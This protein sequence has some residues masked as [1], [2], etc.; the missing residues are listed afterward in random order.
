[1]TEGFFS[2]DAFFAAAADAYYPGRSWRPA[3]VRA[4]EHAWR[5]LEVGDGELVHDC[6]FLDYLEPLPQSGG[7]VLPSRRARFLRRTLARVVTAEQA[8]AVEPSSLV[9]PFIRWTSFDS[10]EAFRALVRSRSKSCFTKADRM[11][12]K[13][14]REVGELRFVEHSDEASV[15]EALFRFK[16]AQYLR[17]GLP[18]LFA[19]R[20]TRRLFENLLSAGALQMSVLY[21]GERI[22]ALHAGPRHGDRFLHWVPTYDPDL[23]RYAPGNTLNHELMRWSFDAGDAVFDLLLGDEPYKWRYATHVALVEP[24]GTPPLKERLRVRAGRLA[25]RA[26]AASPRA[27]GLA[28]ELRRRL[29]EREL[30]P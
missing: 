17:T 12:R 20:G 3:V 2:S 1:M 27:Y 8:S 10:F 21:A 28:K 13:L 26:F 19:S 23:G 15:L 4:G 5:V 24:I 18:D 6:R 14:G 30:L 9:A 25:R 16:S 22:A 29:R 11:A 7:S